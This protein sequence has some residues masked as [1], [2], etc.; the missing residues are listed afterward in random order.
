MG[1]YMS[2]VSPGSG[3]AP[4]DEGGSLTRD[5]GA[6]GA[7]ARRWQAT[8]VRV[9]VRWMLSRFWGV[10]LLLILWQGWIWVA[11][12]NRL[13]MPSPAD[14]LGDL[15]KRPLFYVP[16]LLITVKHTVLGLSIGVCFGLLLAVVTWYS[17]ILSGIVSLPTLLVRGTPIAAMTPVLG[18]VFGFNE[19]SVIVVTILISFFPTY[20]FVS[21]GLN[22]VS[23]S[24]DDIF[25][26]LSSPRSIRLWRLALPAAVPS[27][28]LAVRASAPV[29][30]LGALVAEWLLG[31]EGLGA[32]LAV[33]R[34]TY[35][36]NTVW[37]AAILGTVLAVAVFAGAS[38]S[39]RVGRERWM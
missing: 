34:F 39:E 17:P 5:Q 8:R 9:S 31:V 29:A 35:Q 7:P 36:V 12:I 26:A 24:A 11:D 16:D 30:V 38:W 23:P 19:T 15:V 20:I 22:S 18:R 28:L 32:L 2:G 1:Y 25:S 10:V 21:S 13:V 37:A 33:S 4:R 14:V 3:D 6:A 27:L